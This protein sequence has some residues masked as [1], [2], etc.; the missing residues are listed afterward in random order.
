MTSSINHA[1]DGVQHD[2]V[3][4]FVPCGQR[5]LDAYHLCQNR[6]DFLIKFVAIQRIERAFPPKQAFDYGGRHP[7]SLH[8]MYAPNCAP[9]LDMRHNQL[10]PSCDRTPAFPGIATITRSFDVVTTG[11]ERHILIACQCL[12]TEPLYCLF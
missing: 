7:P 5:H 2:V 4:F 8:P 1:P 12:K 6:F 10:R 3:E 9:A 11:L